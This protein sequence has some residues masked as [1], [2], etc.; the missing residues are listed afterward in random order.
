[1]QLE[2]TVTVIV[3]SFAFF[4]LSACPFICHAAVSAPNRTATA[5]KTALAIEHIRRC[6]AT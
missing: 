2:R 5:V 4:V 6:A 1:M 3:G